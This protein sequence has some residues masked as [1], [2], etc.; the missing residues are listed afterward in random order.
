MSNGSMGLSTRS[1]VTKWVT[2]NSHE[3]GFCCEADELL[4]FILGGERASDCTWCTFI[5]FTLQKTYLPDHTLTPERRT[6][7]A[8]LKRS[9]VLP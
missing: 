8:A 2:G 1:C 3:K 5:N 6:Q 4:Y 7:M 9:D